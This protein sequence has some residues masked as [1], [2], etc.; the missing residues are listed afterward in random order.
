M[1]LT[2]AS[3][4]GDRVTG[5]ARNKEKAVRCENTRLE[6]G[7]SIQFAPGRPS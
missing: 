6:A 2:G 3:K 1:P 7:L 5:L 4:K